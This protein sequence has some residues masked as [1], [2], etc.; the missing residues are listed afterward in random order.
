M[1]LSVAHVA[2][3]AEENDEM[4]ANEMAWR[5]EV[6]AGLAATVVDVVFRVGTRGIDAEKKFVFDTEVASVAAEGGLAAV[7]G[8]VEGAL[9]EDDGYGAG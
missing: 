1:R 2:V 5:V 8:L 4:E 9:E 6:D 7:E 3:M